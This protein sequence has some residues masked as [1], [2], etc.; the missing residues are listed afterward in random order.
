MYGVRYRM[1]LGRNYVCLLV[2]YRSL[3]KAWG[4]AGAPRCPFLVV[5]GCHPPHVAD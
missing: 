4:Q 5:P 3:P 1:T 2:P